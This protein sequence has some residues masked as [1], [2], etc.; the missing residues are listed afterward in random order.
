MGLE[1]DLKTDPDTDPDQ[2]KD[3]DPGVVF[4]FVCGS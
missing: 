2:A 3:A 4:A 1:P